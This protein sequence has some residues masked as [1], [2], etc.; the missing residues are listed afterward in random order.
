MSDEEEQTFAAKW[1]GLVFA[2]CIAV[3]LL[4]LL[5]EYLFSFLQRE[6]TKQGHVIPSI[7]STDKKEIAPSTEDAIKEPPKKYGIF[8]QISQ[9]KE[10]TILN[11]PALFSI[12][13]IL[14]T[15]VQLFVQ[16]FDVLTDSIITGKFWED[17]KP[18][19]AAISY[20][21]IFAP[22]VAKWVSF[23]EY[24]ELK[25]KQKKLPRVLSW[26]N[27]FFPLG[28]FFP[29]IADLYIVSR[30]IKGHTIS[31]WTGKPFKLN[32]ELFSLQR[33]FALQEAQIESFPQ[34]IFQLFLVFT[35]SIEDK[36]LVALSIAI[37]ST[38]LFLQIVQ[39]RAL[40]QKESYPSIFSLMG[41]LFRGEFIS[42][43]NQIKE[44]T[45]SVL[46]LFNVSIDSTKMN[47]VSE[48][49]E[50]QP[51]LRTIILNM[52][53]LSYPSQFIEPWFYNLNTISLKFLRAADVNDIDAAFQHLDANGDGEISIDE[54]GKL[55][56]TGIS[57]FWSHKYG[58]KYKMN[59]RAIFGFIRAEAV[60]VPGT[61]VSL[62]EI[63]TD[64]RFA[65][66]TRMKAREI[67]SMFGKRAGVDNLPE[68]LSL[69]KDNLESSSSTYANKDTALAISTDPEVLDIDV[70]KSNG[71]LTFMNGF[72][73]LH[74]LTSRVINVNP[75]KNFS[76]PNLV[77]LNLKS[78]NV[79]RV[80]IIFEGDLPN[81]KKIDLSDCSG[82][83]DSDITSFKGVPKLEDLDLCRS[84][85]KNV[86]AIFADEELTLK[87]LN[88]E[89]CT[90]LDTKS[91]ESI[92]LI[93]LE[94]LNLGG[95]NWE[96]VAALFAAEL[97]SLKKLNME[98]CTKLDT[99]SIE[100][101]GLIGLED[102][103]LGS[104]NWENVC[105]LFAAEFPS[106]KKL[107]MYRCTELDTKSIESI[108]LIGLEE[109]ELTASNWEK[110][111]A[112]SLLNTKLPSLKIN[113]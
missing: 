40:A 23:G 87:K 58:D 44:N 3:V 86:N 91:I 36:G 37:A 67:I 106:L 72:H 31:L 2:Y 48:I 104:S 70:T 110:K 82:I 95:S 25:C 46:N 108:G 88:M 57:S 8:R 1:A 53:I 107:N 113:I 18:L 27:F 26:F 19:E 62:F 17:D 9:K 15:L 79:N 98:K 97:P 64:E 69:E 73:L 50:H 28:V 56:G 39:L 42:G 71:N 78:S 102:L 21:L 111:D 109:L 61:C 43:V 20:S 5:L 63:V 81:L 49:V 16:I 45:S 74:K 35:G 94:D 13:M 7:E 12:T 103:N 51:S 92:G 24:I 66:D 101:I 41:A 100:S 90:K 68:I 29:F 38:S 93:G 47:L 55:C 10:Q 89:K 14:V 80:S 6:S 77:E 33:T 59:K 60:E 11:F 96:N 83:M 75:L 22:C 76:L 54:L 52:D 85:W 105:F 99:K 112:L 32:D 4:S 65:D 84:N 34:A 30:M